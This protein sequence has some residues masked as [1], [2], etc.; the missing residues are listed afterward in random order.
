MSRRSSRYLGLAGGILCLLPPARAF[1]TGYT[2]GCPSAP[3]HGTSFGSG[4]PYTLALSNFAGTAS[5]YS[6]G[7]AYTLV[8]QGTGGRQFKG[9]VVAGF[10][11]TGVPAFDTGI[12]VGTIATQA[13]AQVRTEVAKGLSR[14]PC[15]PPHSLSRRRS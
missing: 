7:Q 2:D 9:F 1:P 3:G 8:L 4:A 11:Q 5:L 14:G 13:A 10:A 15:S 12:T 6:P